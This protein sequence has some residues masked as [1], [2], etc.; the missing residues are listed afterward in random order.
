MSE[1]TNKLRPFLPAK[2]SP[3][4][5]PLA[6]QLVKL[7]LIATNQVQI[8]ADD[9]RALR[10]IPAGAGVI[11]TPNHADEVD[12]LVCLEL[13]RMSGRKF[14]MMCNREAFDEWNGL[15][16]WGLQRVGIFSVERGGHDAQ[17]KKFAADVVK[18]GR[19]ALVI[20]PE[21]EIFYL[22]ES[23]QPF[24]SGAVDIGI[25][26][27]LDARKSSPDWTSYIVPVAI[28]YRYTKNMDS[29]LETRIGSLERRLSMNAQGHE[30]RKRLVGILT[31]V[32][33]QKAAAHNLQAESDKIHLLSD[34]IKHVRH[35]MLMEVRQK[36]Q[37]LAATQASTIDRAWQLSG[38]LRDMMAKGVS[39]EK[40]AQMQKDLNDLK[41]VGH[42]VS[43]QPQ[44]FEASDS[45]DRLAEVVLKLERE[46]YGITRPRQLAHREVHLR[47][48]TPLDLS[49]YIERYER[50]PHVLRHELSEQL[51]GTI[52]KLID[53]I[54]GIA[55]A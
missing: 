46:V 22:N 44:Y 43:L 30:M 11:V 3:W 40:R 2:P 8:G 35:A 5:L 51:R 42:M 1:P 31:T 33:Q 49:Q 38:Q 26:A 52:Q 19:D 28:K 50:D 32:L 7:N 48:G 39:A 23:V 6:Q 34:R 10:A 54:A 18:N 36:Y 16:G 15:A 14:I 4:L 27:I 53:E 47:V 24:H 29:I 25:R 21:G 13:S 17:A 9:L 55:T 37:E 41:E 20:F 12:P 45:A